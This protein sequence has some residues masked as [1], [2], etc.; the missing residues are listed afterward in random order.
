MRTQTLWCASPVVARAGVLALAVSLAG[1]TE[2]R[3]QRS[4]TGVRD[5]GFGS[6]LP[7]VPTTVHPN[8][9]AR[10]GQFQITGEPNDP[11]EIRFLLPSMLTGP[12]AAT[13]NVSFGTTSAGFSPS[14]SITNQEFF[15][16][17]TSYSTNLSSTGRGT[18]FLGGI[19]TPSGT[20]PAGSYSGSVTIIVA[21][22][23]Q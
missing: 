3:A 22:L 16:P 18:G 2:L 10:S 21:F 17:R 11:V 20:Q 14:G 13:M 12:G 9:V 1:A 4:A 19:L 23:G 8:D 6:V 7:G 5:L 15:D